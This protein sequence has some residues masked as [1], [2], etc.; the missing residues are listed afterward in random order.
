M[1]KTK[2]ESKKTLPKD[3]V[4]VEKEPKDVKSQL[5]A[6]VEKSHT[7]ISKYL[8]L[9][10]VA[11]SSIT[12]IGALLLSQHYINPTRDEQVYT[13]GQSQVNY[14]QIDQEKLQTLE[15]SLEETSVTVEP[16]FV[17]NR[18]NPFSE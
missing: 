1:S 3:E 7:I 17:P 4:V 2:K 8:L 10:A 6:F 13:D 15:N 11:T 5:T 12:V 14:R 18:R 16:E 9:F